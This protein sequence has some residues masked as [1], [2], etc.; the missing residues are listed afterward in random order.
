MGHVHLTAEAIQYYERLLADPRT[1]ADMRR[2]LALLL[3][4]ARGALPTEQRAS[5]P[6]LM[7]GRRPL[8]Q[9]CRDRLGWRTF[10]DAPCQGCTLL[11]VCTHQRNGE[12]PAGCA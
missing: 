2:S 1:P 6:Y 12:R 8:W 3:A 9:A 4:G 10:A 7:R 11:P 5:S